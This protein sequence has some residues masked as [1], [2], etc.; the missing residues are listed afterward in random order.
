MSL[1]PSGSKLRVS[2]R[3]NVDHFLLE[4]DDGAQSLSSL[5]IVTDPDIRWSSE[6]FGREKSEKAIYFLVA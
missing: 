3:K 6:K 4:D 5:Q 1:P 2:M